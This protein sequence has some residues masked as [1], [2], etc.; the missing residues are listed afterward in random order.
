MQLLST[1]LN[2][3]I[4][5]SVAGSATIAR[6][7]IN[8]YSKVGL[9][10]VLIQLAPATPPT[11]STNSRSMVEEDL[12]LHAENVYSTLVK[13]SESSKT[14]VKKAL[15]QAKSKGLIKNYRYYLISNTFAV[16]APKELI[17][18]IAKLP[19]VEE[20]TSNKQFRAPT[21]GNGEQG[22]GQAGDTTWDGKEIHWSLKYINATDIPRHVSLAASRLRYANADTGVDFTH[23]ALSKNYLGNK[24]GKLSHDYYW[25]DANKVANATKPNKI[26]GIDSQVPCDDNNHGTHCMGSAVGGLNLGVSPTTPWMACKNMDQNFGSPE[27][28]LGCLQFLLA[29]TNLYGTNPKPRLRPHVI[30]NSYYCPGEEGCSRSTFKYALRALKSAGIFMSVCA[31]NDGKLGCSSILSPPATEPTSFTVAASKYLSNDRAAFSSMGPVPERPEFAID[32]TAPGVNITSSIPGGKYAV[33]QGTSMA[34]PHVAGAALLVIAACPHLNRRVDLIA[35]VL[36]ESA[37]PNYSNLGCGKDLATSLPNNEYGFGILNV[38]K[39]LK[40]CKK[41]WY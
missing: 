38:A 1:I 22:A 35:K 19:E 3:T 18:T 24:N 2:L 27:S 33:F 13:H 36:R 32:I 40:L 5:Y 20:I 37:T 25:W 11:I 17:D 39:A 16:E 21:Q 12:D 15:D 29:P 7:V 31:G 4:L 30:G 34:T 28:Y 14:N 10:S 9:S 8:D 6:S 26:C 23:P 41:T